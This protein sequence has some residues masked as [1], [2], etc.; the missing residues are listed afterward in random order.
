MQMLMFVFVGTGVFAATGQR[1]DACSGVPT[2]RHRLIR[3]A[4]DVYGR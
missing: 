4:V 2:D 3:V 1:P